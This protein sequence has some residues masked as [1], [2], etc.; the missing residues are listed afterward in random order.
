M[1]NKIKTPENSGKGKFRKGLLTELVQPS[2]VCV[3]KIHKKHWTLLAP[4][5]NVLVSSVQNITFI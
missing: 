5:G 2:T 3:N 4:G 1:N